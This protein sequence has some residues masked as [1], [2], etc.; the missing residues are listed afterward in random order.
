MHDAMHVQV[1]E[2]WGLKNRQQ[3]YLA[4][5]GAGMG[6]AAGSWSLPE[7]PARVAALA[8]SRLALLLDRLCLRD[9]SSFSLSLPLLDAG[10]L[11]SAA[12][13]ALQSNLLVTAT[14]G[15]LKRIRLPENS[16]RRSLLMS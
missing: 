13:W 16:V 3:L 7:E 4:S 11:S 1:R 14:T 9:G 6:R 5:G 10:L 12:V 2:T 8:T 15:G